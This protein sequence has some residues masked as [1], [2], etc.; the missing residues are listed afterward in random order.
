[1]RAIFVSA[2]LALALTAPA[3]AQPS[4]ISTTN[5]YAWGEN[6]GFINCRDANSAAQGVVVHQSFLF[7]YAWGEN[8]G[9]I[10][11]G[12]G[13]PGFLGRYGNTDGSDA[14]VNLACNGNLSGYA[15]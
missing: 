2:G 15:W 9:W 4:N 6:V 1:M 3:L 12:D 10:N 7:G 8:I 5:K 14:G 13:S 11:F